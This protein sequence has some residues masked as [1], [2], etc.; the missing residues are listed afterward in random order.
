MT[1]AC[2]LN[3]FTLVVLICCIGVCACDPKMDLA[4]LLHHI[5]GFVFYLCCVC[6][7]ATDATCTYCLVVVLLLSS[8]VKFIVLNVIVRIIIV[9]M[10]ESIIV[11]HFLNQKVLSKSPLLF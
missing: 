2:F 7:V 6:Y 5:I 10:I 1:L 11:K 8:I 4:V 9:L 3:M